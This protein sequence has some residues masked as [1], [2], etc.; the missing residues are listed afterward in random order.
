MLLRVVVRPLFVFQR[1]AGLLQ[2]YFLGAHLILEFDVFLS[3]PHKSS[4]LLLDR[5]L[6]RRDFGSELALSSLCLVPVRIERLARLLQEPLLGLQLIPE[7][8][9]FG[10]LLV[11]G[12]ASL[13]QEALLAGELLLQLLLRRDSAR[14]LDIKGLAGFLK[15]RLLRGNAFF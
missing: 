9:G 14:L 12:L 1:L 4:V 11:Q 6:L 13:A 5:G 10:F 8:T 7:L 15:E 3:L 2:E